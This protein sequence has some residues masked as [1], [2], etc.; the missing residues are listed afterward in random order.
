LQRKDGPL[1]RVAWNEDEGVVANTLPLDGHRASRVTFRSIHA[2]EDEGDSMRTSLIVAICAAT[3][4]LFTA[5]SAR[6]EDLAQAWQIAL[7]S[8]GLLQSQQAETTA[9]G[10]N[11][12]AARSARLPTLRTYTFNAFLTATPEFRNN[13]FGATSKAGDAPPAGMTALPVPPSAFSFFGPGQRDLPASITYASV[14]LYTGGRIPRNIEAADAQLGA[15]RSEEFRTSLDLKLNVAEAYIGVVRAQRNLEVSK[16]SVEQL[17]SFARDAHNRLELGQVLRSD[18]LAA[19]VSLANARLAE[20]QARTSLEVAWATY[21]RYL[22][23]PLTHIGQLEELAV[24][25]IPGDGKDSAETATNEASQPIVQDESEVRDLTERAYRER[26]EL[27]GFSEQARS[28]ASQA[29]ATS[30]GIRPQA[31]FSMAFLY[32][33]NNVQIHQGIGVATFYVDWTISDGGASR[34]QAAALRQRELAALRRRADAA[35]DVALQVRSRWLELI[36]ARRKLPV[37]RLSITQALNDTKVHS[38]RYR[39]GLSTYTDVLDAEN[40]RVQSLNNFFNAVYDERT[41]FFRL[42]RAV[43]N[44]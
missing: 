25:A 18:E 44:L 43:G 6:S 20:I 22:D 14:P 1:G 10:L 31:G 17:G 26:P 41:A 40:R 16:S 12:A 39:N 11:V 29:Q 15:Q 24:L 32:L 28:F 7:R 27:S 21:N 9:A 8:N 36:Q 5:P 4:G 30:A 3:F 2:D 23:C 37:T 19:Q 13:F 38:D 42:R 35:A 33:G 34:R